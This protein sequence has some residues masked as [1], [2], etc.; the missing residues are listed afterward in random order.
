[1]KS[2]K[3]VFYMN[4]EKILKY[5]S[6]GLIILITVLLMVATVVEKFYGSAFVHQYIYSSPVMIVLWGVMALS[7]ICYL[8]HKGIHKQKITFFFFFLFVL[9][10]AGALTTHICGRRGSLHL[11]VGDD[12]VSR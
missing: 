7:A 6:F 11:R 1:M 9:I 2:S 8:L 12:A 4:K 10:L 3:F 5:T